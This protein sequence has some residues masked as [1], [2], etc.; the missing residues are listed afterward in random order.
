MRYRM[1]RVFVVVAFLIAPSPSFAKPAL[2]P[3]ILG[4]SFV[5]FKATDLDKSTTFY[6][7][8]LGLR[9]GRESCKRLPAPCFSINS[10]QHIELVPA[11]SA[12]PASFLDEIGLLTNDLMGM[13]A[14][15]GAHQI[16]CTEISTAPNGVHFF[17]FSDP[18][19]N[20][21]AFTED[22]VRVS[23]NTDRPE[24]HFINTPTQVGNRLIH[25]GFVVKDLE[26]MKKFYVDLLG[27]RLYWYGGFKDDGVDWYEIQVPDGNNWIEFMLNISPTA[28]HKELG[29]QNH[30]SLGVKNVHTAAAELRAHG[31]TTFDGPEVGRDGKD[32]LDIYD[33]DFSRVEVMEF[34]PAQTPCC[35]P[36]T[37]PHP[38]L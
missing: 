1:H 19:G 22:F 10:S 6:S 18:E 27:F 26:L 21:L 8:I 29:V 23:L 7:K 32:S 36:Y 20:A 5:R 14:Y 24:D 35:H 30:F 17:E 34:T 12:N 25:A 37:A 28:D 4:I 15:L 16:N 3:K 11:R 38:K 31:A 13:R 2:R 33:P 9:S